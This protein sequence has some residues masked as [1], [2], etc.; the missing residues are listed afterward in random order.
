MKKEIKRFVLLVYAMLLWSMPA[1]SET[2]SQKTAMSMA[3]AFFNTLYGYETPRPKLVWSGRELTTNRLFKP[4]YVYNS[5][6]GGFV[7]I[8]ADS[9]AFPVLAYSRT[10]RFDKS[11]LNDME[12]ERFT[13][14]AREVE[15]I[16]YDSRVP[17]KAK[18]AWENLP[19]YITQVL[20]NPY[21]TDE[22]RRLT[23][24]VRAEIEDI[25]RRNGWIIM[26]TAV[27]FN[28][29]NPEQYRDYTLDDVL[30]EEVPFSFYD[31]FIRELAEEEAA[32]TASYE[33]ILIPTEPKV[34][35]NGG[36]HYTITFPDEPK[37]MRIYSINGTRVQEKT[38]SGN[39]ALNF[40][41]SGQPSGYYV[42]M[43]LFNDGKIYGFKVHR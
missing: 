21:N 41:L 18:A 35:F 6:R 42:V 23:D 37:V 25:D 38:F 31:E 36:G 16:R 8:V 20:A 33:K 13:R 28:L 22:Y 5:P 2:V 3:Q 26:P 34:Q 32:R 40:D 4:F 9:K 29:Y 17:V 15:L 12:R 10:N 43:V 11:S 27:E 24:D 39:N 30:V 7:V 19:E 1:L 14:F